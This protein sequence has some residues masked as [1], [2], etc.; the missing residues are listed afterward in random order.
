MTQT[1]PG[2]NQKRRRSWQPR[3][4][5][6]RDDGEWSYGRVLRNKRLAL[7][8]TGI[9]VS[10]IGDG[11]ILTALPVETLRIHGS[12]DPAIAIALVETAPYV[13]ATALAV[14]VG[15]GKV[16]P[17]PRILL[18]LDSLLRAVM[19]TILG[20]LALIG[21]LSL[22]VLIAG[23]LLGSVFRLVALGGYR[24]VATGMVPKQ[25]RFA[26]NALLGISS[27][28]A[29][30][31]VGPAA[32]GLVAGAAGPGWVLLIYG[33]SFLVLLAVILFAVS[34]RSSTPGDQVAR[35]SGWQILRR[36]PLAARLFA[37]VFFFNLLYMPVEVAL[38]LIVQ[39]PMHAGART[40]GTIWSGFGV[41]ALVGALATNHL[42][43]LPRHILLIAIIAAWGGSVLLLA[44]SPTV[45]V[46]ALS[47]SLG[48]MIYAPFT[49]VAYSYVQ[50]VLAADEQQP[51][52]TLWTMGT[53]LASPIG[54][55]ASGPLV[56]IVGARGGL[57]LSALT[58]VALAIIASF[59]LRSGSVAPANPVRPAHRP[60]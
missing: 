1:P 50:S 8:L 48:G 24:V 38:P 54:L 13:V 39:G 26:V 21:A 2:A 28:V 5:L 52:I 35:L 42:R 36:V 44:V 33:L 40:L 55:L 31:V 15:L 18:S 41:G 20:S 17:R 49:P 6:A 11:M 14:W 19:F 56:A 16:R 58:T 23:L 30:F 9:V 45:G 34:S 60:E 57:L 7:L 37:V 3:L 59:S 47:F 12:L 29:A 32:G 10:N 22:P 46:A 53:T 43:R 4:P 25:G 27:N 51:V